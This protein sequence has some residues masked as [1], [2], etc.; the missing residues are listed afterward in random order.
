MAQGNLEACGRGREGPGETG[1]WRAQ[2]CLYPTTVHGFFCHEGN[3]A[4]AQGPE[5]PCKWRCS[6][7]GC[8]G[9]WAPG[10][11]SLTHGTK[12]DWVAF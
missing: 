5:K 2:F 10:G 1:E 11:R 9:L 12:L 3:K 6:K 7:P 4:V 8:M